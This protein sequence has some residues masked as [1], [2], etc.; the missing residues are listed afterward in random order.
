[1]SETA[2]NS[3]PAHAAG[4]RTD[5]PAAARAGDP[6]G[7]D[8]PGGDPPSRVIERGRSKAY[9]PLPAAARRAALAAGLAAYERG[10]FFAAHELL[11]PA[12]MGSNDPAERALTSGLIKLAAGFVHAV[13]G[14][15]AG[16][17][18]NL[19]GARVRLAA[20]VEAEGPDAGLD[21]PR[22]IEAIDD[23]LRRLAPLVASGARGASLPPGDMTAPALPRRP[24]R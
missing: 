5:R 13:R 9:R 10:D 18:T 19:R 4:H 11:E 1:M 6:P 20:A 7:R 23:R 22:L 17:A 14:N 15:P 16:I 3:G 24:A 8:P 21:L 2:G 12:W